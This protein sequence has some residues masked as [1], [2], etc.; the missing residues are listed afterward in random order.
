MKRSEQKARTKYNIRQAF[1]DLLQRKEMDNIT[2]TEL[3]KSAN[4]DRKT[5]YL[6]YD[7][8]FDVY[9][10]I[11]DDVSN[12]LD[13][14]LKQQNDFDF[15]IFFNELNQVMQANFKFYQTIAKQKS[16]AYLIKD[17]TDILE[18]GLTHYYLSSNQTTSN[19]IKIRYISNGI[20]GVYINWLA[21]PN[22]IS[23][24]ELVHILSD[25]L[26]NDIK[27]LNN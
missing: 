15:F 9:H 19:K 3:A 21:Q 23:Q 12:Q 13:N 24:D 5:F 6:H 16:Y 25:L 10:D 17:F 14:I 11:I 8:T 18:N 7:T 27:H 26:E 1:I 20:M 2:I 22:N 4:I